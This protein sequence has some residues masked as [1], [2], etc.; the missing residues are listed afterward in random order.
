MNSW[1]YKSLLTWRDFTLPIPTIGGGLYASRGADE[2]FAK[3]IFNNHILSI[4]S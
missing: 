3:I 1:Q 2:K 4:I